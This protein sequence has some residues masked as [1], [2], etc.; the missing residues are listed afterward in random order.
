MLAEKSGKWIGN[1]Y[2]NDKEI[3]LY[4]PIPFQ[5]LGKYEFSLS[6]AMRIDSLPGIENVALIIEEN[7]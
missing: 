4:L 6:Q 5:E 2:G 3:L 7:E 1:S